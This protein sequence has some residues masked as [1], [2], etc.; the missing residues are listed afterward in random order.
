MQQCRPGLGIPQVIYPGQ[1]PVVI[2]FTCVPVSQNDFPDEVGI[3]SPIAHQK[4]ITGCVISG[5]R[6]EE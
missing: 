1:Y 6:D 4:G 3:F 2:K 5:G